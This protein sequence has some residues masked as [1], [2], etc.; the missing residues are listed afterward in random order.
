MGMVCALRVY[1][2]CGLIHVCLL[3]AIKYVTLHSVPFTF[4]SLHLL[5]ISLDPIIIVVA[6]HTNKFNKA[7][8]LFTKFSYNH[9]VI[10]HQVLKN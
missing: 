8:C 6:K 4:H 3:N 1:Q 7:K 9:W 10:F 2:F 5:F